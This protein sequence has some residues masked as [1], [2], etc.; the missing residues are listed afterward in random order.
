MRQLHSSSR[1]G[2]ISKADI[3]LGHKG[4]VMAKNWEHAAGIVWSLLVVAAKR[5]ETRIY[6]VDIAP[7]INTNA[8]SVTHALS[9][10][11]DYC[12]ESR[13]PPLTA[14]AVN[15]GGIPGSGFIAWDVDDLVSAHQ[16]VFAYDWEKIPN[17]YASFGPQDTSASLAQ[18]IVDDPGNAEDVY[19]QVRVRG[20]IQI[21]FRAALIK[22]YDGQ[23]A[24]C[25]STFKAAMDAAH[26]K[27]WQTSTP[28][29]RLDTRNGLLLCA[30]HHRLLDAGLITVSQSHKVHYCDPGME[31]R[32]YSMCDKGLTVDLHGKKIYLP[33]DQRHWPSRDYLTAHHREKRWGTVP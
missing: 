3:T 2:F 17:P 20:V 21:I 11:Q 8:L 32:Q 23:C 16:K 27:S 5:N 14:I 33:S 13:L 4:E 29:E 9:P 7:A 30:T 6:G 19:T 28:K 12:L 15:K 24:I 10:I 1:I 22:A 26:L 31:K 18:K 25:G